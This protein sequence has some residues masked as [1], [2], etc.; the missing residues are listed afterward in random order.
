MPLLRV[1]LC[2]RPNR[3]V[4]YVAAI[5]VVVKRRGDRETLSFCDEAESTGFVLD[6]HAGTGH[7]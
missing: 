6:G 7:E 1:Y 4:I 3:R 2:A 5:G